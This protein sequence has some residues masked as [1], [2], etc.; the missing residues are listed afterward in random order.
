[1]LPIRVNCRVKCDAVT[2]NGHSR[3]LVQDYLIKDLRVH[4]SAVDIYRQIKMST[5]PDWRRRLAVV[6]NNSRPS[7]RSRRFAQH[8]R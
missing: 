1:M 2:A 7:T 4:Q 3:R 5:L 6:D 8:R